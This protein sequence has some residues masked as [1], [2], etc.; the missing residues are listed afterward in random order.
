MRFRNAV[1]ISIDNFACVFKSLFYRL[2]IGVIFFS[3]AYVILSTGMSV[4]FRSAQAE[5]LRSLVGEFFRALFSGDVER[6][7]TFQTDFHEALGALG[8]L[9]ADN[10][11][12]I[13]GSGIGVCVM[14]LLAR[15]ANGLSVFAVGGCINDRMSGCTR[16]SFSVA[17]FRNASRG[18]LYQ[19]IYV[20]L[21][22]LYDVLTALACWFLFF[23]VLSRIMSWGVLT[24]LIAL[25]LT[26]TFVACLQALKMTLVSAWMPGIIADGKRVGGAMAQSFRA[27]KHFGGRFASF[28]VAVYIIIIANVACA[29]C[30]FGS[31]LLL[32]LPLSFVFLLALQ[33]VEYYE[34]MGRKYFISSR[35]IVGGEDSTKY[36]G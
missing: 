12:S 9:M 25:A 36:L 14:Y 23:Y 2:C 29:L 33:F 11:G 4:I 13:V 21:I 19:L 28:L 17:F 20:P 8:R 3:L 15:F 18:T 31:A 1:H 6:L 7:Q 16:T 32:S 27:K 24:I 35:K 22:F 34:D 10:V 5:E 30:T 26:M